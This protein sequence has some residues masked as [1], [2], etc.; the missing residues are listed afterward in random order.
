MSELTTSKVN[1]Q[2][3][4]LRSKCASL[5]SISLAPP[6]PKVAVTYGSSLR[7]ATREHQD[8]T[9]PLAILQSLDKLGSR[10]HFDRAI[11]ENMQLSKRIY[12]V[13]DAFKN[14]VQSTSGLPKPDSPVLSRI[15]PLAGI[16]AR[17]VG[18]H[19]EVEMKASLGDLSDDEGGQ[20]EIRSQ[21]M[22]E[23][24]EQVPSQYRNYTLVA[25]A[26]TYILNTC[27]HH[28]TLLHALLE[29][30]AAHCLLAEARV[31]LSALFTA[32]I[33]PRP[34]STS[35]C[36]L[37]HPAHKNFLT[38]LREACGS[39]AAVTPIA[40][41]RTYTHIL[42]DALSQ[43]CLEQLHAWTSRA[44]I[45][46]SRELAQQDFAGCFVPLVSGLATA[47][48]QSKQ[49]RRSA[50]KGGT[51][52]ARSKVHEEALE[53]LAKWLAAML[54]TLY[55]SGPTADG[56]ANYTACVDFL[57][58]V[59]PLQ[60]HTLSAP[61]A[62]PGACVVDALCC[63]TAYCLASP[64]ASTAAVESDLCVLE[65]IL[66]G[67][68]VRNQTLNDLVSR[69][70]P[71]PSFTMFRMPLSEPSEHTPTPPPGDFVHGNGA[72]GEIDALATPLRARGLLRCEAALYRGALEHV[73]IL[74]SSPP[75]TVAPSLQLGEKALHDFRL[76]LL[77]RAEDAERR[78]YGNATDPS[79]PPDASQEWVWEEMV[80]SW[81]AKSPAPVQAKIAKD[82]DL[83]RAAKRRRVESSSHVTK[84]EKLSNGSLFPAFRQ[85]HSASTGRGRNTQPTTPSTA[86]PIV[87][88]D[89]ENSSDG[90]DY[91]DV[92][93]DPLVPGDS[94]VDDTPVPVRVRKFANTL[95]YP[96]VPRSTI[97]FGAA[98][99]AMKGAA[100][101]RPRASAPAR[102]VFAVPDSPASASASP[103]VSASAPPRRRSNFVSLIADSHKNVVSLREEKARARARASMGDAPGLGERD[104]KR[105]HLTHGYGGRPNKHSEEEEEDAARGELVAPESSP[106][107]GAA[108][109]EPSSD[110]ALDLFAYPDSSP[111]ASRRR[112]H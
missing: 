66:R 90:E 9:P 85:S 16:C 81:V 6:R 40:N 57:V 45:R 18:E 87:S 78:C 88:W 46:L 8:D 102:V 25:H 61:P 111:A 17:V 70:L 5:T 99:S 50:S 21:I 19:V 110:D 92:G 94:T 68:T 65:Q 73:E 75:H 86:R 98:R 32:A 36:P 12:E 64:L 52:H 22:D 69:I 62:S 28:P 30:C 67:A 107:R 58:A 39:A 105:K 29:V 3:R 53:R 112:F 100:K 71:L 84:P 27:P 93:T 77:D 11:V 43:P 26:L 20:D 24:Y 101:P 38:T 35:A 103:S 54:N 1:R 80:G 108:V 95:T 2:F 7:N 14:I 33:F 47:L 82:R 41:D 51:E 4:S 31:V 76:Q 49:S 59:E 10:L 44:V 74:I 96:N 97:S 91:Q 37:T 104:R 55:G 56:T 13:R 15:L 48:W 72:I 89:K 60:F 83:E 23:L 42:I 106:F 34:Y 63:L 109:A 79:R